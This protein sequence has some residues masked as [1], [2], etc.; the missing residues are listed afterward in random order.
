MYESKLY[1]S[2]SWKERKKYLGNRVSSKAERGQHR[3]YKDFGRTEVPESMGVG[4]ISDDV[5]EGD[6]LHARDRRDPHQV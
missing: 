4:V 6:I 5:A 2:L 3:S 1:N